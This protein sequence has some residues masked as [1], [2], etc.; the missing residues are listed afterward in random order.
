METLQYN[1]QAHS[2]PISAS[3]INQ[4]AKE[5]T[6]GR[7][8]D[9]V[10]QSIESSWLV[11]V[12]CL[13][14]KAQWTVPFKKASTSSA[15][16]H[17]F[18]S[19]LNCQMMQRHSTMA[20]HEDSQAQICI[21]PY[22]TDNAIQQQQ[23]TPQAPAQVKWNAM[24][25]L[26]RTNTLAALQSLQ[27]HIASHASA[28]RSIMAVSTNPH[29]DVHLS[30]PRFTLRSKTNLTSPLSALGVRDAFSQQK[31]SFPHIVGS[32][33]PAWIDA[34]EHHVFV[35]VNEEGTEV[36]AVTSMNLFGAPMPQY[37]RMCVDRPF[38]F[39][40]FEAV[41]GL[42]LVSAT[43]GSGEGCTFS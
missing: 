7:I 4:F 24:I 36:A 19:Q 11:L 5:N 41:T 20:Y 38:L 29:R 2:A 42:V 23:T 16:F 25:I 15:L 21:L 17:A 37:T 35:E 33:Q 31:A 39:V 28:F 34:V 12:T 9:I 18:D 3:A 30:L 8:T 10:N 43:V 27:T 40:V 22:R 32:E 13:Y 14:F 26:P 6:N 1:F